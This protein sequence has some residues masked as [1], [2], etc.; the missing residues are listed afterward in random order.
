MGEDRGKRKAKRRA[1]VKKKVDINLHWARAVFQA[2]AHDT[3][4]KQIA[5]RRAV[6]KRPVLRLLHCNRLGAMVC[7]CR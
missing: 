2:G 5:L 3:G 6:K 1:A 4:E 7:P